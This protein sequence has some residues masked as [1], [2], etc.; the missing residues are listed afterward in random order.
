MWPDGTHPMLF[1]ELSCVCMPSFKPVAPS[2]FFLTNVPFSASFNIGRGVAIYI[3]K[4]F[5]LMT[6]TLNI[7]IYIYIW[8]CGSN[9]NR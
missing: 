7:Y 9:F 2:F 4:T 8:V 1:S 5:P 6:L 3:L